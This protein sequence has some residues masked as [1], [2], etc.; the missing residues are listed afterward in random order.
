MK[1][2][3]TIALLAL[4]GLVGR[5]SPAAADIT[6][7]LGLNPTPQSHSVRGVAAG[8]S[9]LIVG[10]EFEYAV[11]EEDTTRQLPG[12]QTGMF[13]VLV[14]TPTKTQ[15]YVTAGGGL[16]RETLGSVKVTSTSARTSAAA[17]S[18]TCSAR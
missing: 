15:L 8:V 10:F 9:M 5:P 6:F 16:Y 13:N 2:P 3:L 4:A 11:A 14:M 18:S 12:L 7:F 1:R 17:S